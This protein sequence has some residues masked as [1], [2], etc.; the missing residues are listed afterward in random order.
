[1][2]R[3][4]DVFPS[5]ELREEPSS[6]DRGREG[7]RYQISADEPDSLRGK[8]KREGGAENGA[9]GGIGIGGG[10]VGGDRIGK[11]DFLHFGKREDKDFHSIENIGGVIGSRPLP[12][13][14]ASATAATATEAGDESDDPD[15][16]VGHIHARAGDMIDGRYKVLNESGRGTF[17]K[18]L[19]CE[20]SLAMPSRPRVVAIKVVRSIPRYVE[21]AE[22]ESDI[23]KHVNLADES[24]KVPIV[25]L[26]SSFRWNG[27]FCMVMEPLGDSLYD[28]VKANNYRALPLYCVQ[29]FADQL[30][31]AVVFMHELGLV[32]T[33]LKL[34]NILLVS[35]EGFHK[36]EKPTSERPNAQ[37]LA[38]RGSTQIKI[39]DFGGATYIHEH[40]SSLINTRQYRAPEVI[41]GLG[42]S[43]PSDIWSVG[44]I[45]IELYTGE[46]LFDTHDSAEH[47]LLMEKIIG[48]FP[49]HIVKIASEGHTE[50]KYF[51]HGLVR[52]PSRLPRESLRKVQ[53]QRSLREIVNEKDTVFLDLVMGMLALDPA[54]RITARDAL[55]HRFF[56]SVRK[57]MEV[58][59]PQ[60]F[61]KL[62]PS[63]LQ[64]ASHERPLSNRGTVS[65][66]APVNYIST[67]SGK[68]SEQRPTTSAEKGG[69][70]A[71]HT[72]TS[73]TSSNSYSNS[74]IDNA[75]NNRF[76]P[77]PFVPKPLATK[78]PI[79]INS[80]ESITLS[81]AVTSAAAPTVIT[82][83]NTVS[84]TQYSPVGPKRALPEATTS[85][86][87]A[88]VRDS[89]KPIPLQTIT[90][91][92]AKGDS[93]AKLMISTLSDS[94][95]S[96][97]LAKPSFSIPAAT[98]T[99]QS[100]NLSSGEDKGKTSINV[101]DSS[102]SGTPSG[103]APLIQQAS[104]LQR[105]WVKPVEKVPQLPPPP[106]S[107]TG[108]LGP[109]PPSPSGLLSFISATGRESTPSSSSS[110]S[111]LG[112]L[113]RTGLLA[114]SD[115]G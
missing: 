31:Q 42:W 16:E 73:Y 30:V 78:I 106:P 17:G 100:S 84:I 55:N 87:D 49:R 22:I 25:R 11:V 68:T 2:K 19:L 76:V 92:L 112:L 95:E 58:P 71:A 52:V 111:K 82:A 66:Q 77:P 80:L 27:H 74:S 90:D 51:S 39:I 98:T 7:D 110:S 85:E 44:C 61:Q 47:L 43:L 4:R 107:G 59:I 99:G 1:M 26:Y 15:D 65:T 70:A 35:R 5:K 54:E 101:A 24:L 108:A 33:D 50:S 9:R 48:H 93:G 83:D 97:S 38:P 12:L 89:K 41:L 45:L 79:P 20:D 3:V 46:L 63:K 104:S 28:L 34:E 109:P 69:I 81:S 102:I 21:S 113:P 6:S 64:R 72:S 53:D 91:K 67:S 60:H 115:R 88:Y 105:L 32:H 96:S 36:V 40:K 86:A 94:R 14:T 8:R 114:F 62:Q 29:S 37:T 75:G 57:R 56:T 13:A 18:V 23:L 10:G 103:V